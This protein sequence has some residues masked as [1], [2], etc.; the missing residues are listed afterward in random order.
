MRSN[1]PSGTIRFCF[2]R[3]MGYGSM[4]SKLQL[5]KFPTCLRIVVPTGNLCSFD[6]GERGIIENVRSRPLPWTPVNANA[7]TSWCSSSTSLES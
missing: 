3:M 7:V 4:H 5:L 1:V 6:W 2:P